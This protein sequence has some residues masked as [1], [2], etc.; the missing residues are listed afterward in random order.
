MQR[1]DDFKALATSIVEGR[2]NAVNR[3][4]RRAVV[5]IIAIEVL[6]AVVLGYAVY[7]SLQLA[8]AQECNVLE[9]RINSRESERTTITALRNIALGAVDPGE[10]RFREAIRKIEIPP[11][12]ETEVTA[13]Y[14]REC[15]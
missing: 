4:L 14:R 2:E 7:R 10:D 11:P 15:E 12:I 5:V 8:R 6:I 9:H 3:A 13:E 1:Q